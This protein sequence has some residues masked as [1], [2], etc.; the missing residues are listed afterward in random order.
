MLLR[1]AIA[2]EKED[3]SPLL[4]AQ[5]YADALSLLV[6]R[7]KEIGKNDGFFVKIKPIL[8]NYAE[9]AR[10]LADIAVEE[11]KAMEEARR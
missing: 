7:A 6:E 11:E 9:R 10:L 5:M 8:M 1:T 4:A 3:G 2:E